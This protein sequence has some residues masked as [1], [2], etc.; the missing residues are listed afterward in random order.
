MGGPQPFDERLESLDEQAIDGENVN[1][2]YAAR[3]KRR[4]FEN[5]GI[6]V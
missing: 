1:G 2:K 6:A 3:L 5:H 4:G